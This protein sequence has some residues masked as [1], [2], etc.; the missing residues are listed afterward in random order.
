MGSYYINKKLKETSIEFRKKF[1]KEFTKELIKNSRGDYKDE[2]QKLR[3][4]VEDKERWEKKDL[5]RKVNSKIK[6]KEK[7]KKREA[8]KPS[9]LEKIKKDPKRVFKDNKPFQGISKQQRNIQKTPGNK[10]LQMPQQSK[11]VNI[12]HIPLPKNFQYLKPVPKEQEIDLGKLNPLIK[13]KNVKTIECPGPNQHIFVKGVM[14]TKRSKI[15]LDKN[16]IDSILE[17]FSKKT[18]VPLNEGVFRV[19]YGKLIFSALNK[20]KPEFKITKMIH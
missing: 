20:E 11:R 12:P 5:Q 9:F 6:E 15:V 14:G 18:R 7:I 3:N 10:K 17:E 16:E 4:I 1:L 8:E 13:D 2:L 19:A